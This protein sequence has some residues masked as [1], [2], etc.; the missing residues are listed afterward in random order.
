MILAPRL[1]RI[2][3]ARSALMRT[4]FLIRN[5]RMTPS[6]R[7]AMTAGYGYGYGY[8][9]KYYDEQKTGN[10]EPVRNIEAAPTNENQQPPVA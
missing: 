2:S 4:F 7:A 8:G 9:S 3:E 1:R 10:R 6:T 5:V